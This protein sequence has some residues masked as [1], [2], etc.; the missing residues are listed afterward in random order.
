MGE[1]ESTQDEQEKT[2]PLPKH[3]RVNMESYLRSYLYGPALYLLSVARARQMV[4]AHC[5]PEDP[6][7]ARPRRSS[8]G[9][10]EASSNAGDGQAN[11][12]RVNTDIWTL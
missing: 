2:F 11:T 5:V 4:E 12:Q 7:E 10:R 1:Y 3:H 9:Q 6:R 8:G